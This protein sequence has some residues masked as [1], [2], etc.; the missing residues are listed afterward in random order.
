MH[1]FRMGTLSNGAQ[2]MGRGRQVERTAK[3]KEDA[4]ERW[5]GRDSWIFTGADSVWIDLRK[6]KK[7]K[8]SQFL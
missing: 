5:G 2:T 1:F 8:H 6:I 3:G 7:Y 4:V